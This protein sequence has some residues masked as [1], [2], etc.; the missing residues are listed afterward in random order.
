MKPLS[1]EGRDPLYRIEVKKRAL[2][3]VPL[4]P[5]A[6]REHVI[7]LISMLETDPVPSR[8]FD[9]IKL[10]GYPSSYRVRLGGI[11]VVYKVDSVEHVITVS[12]IESRGRAY[13]DL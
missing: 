2:R 4:L 5:P 3:V 10:E 1:K 7:E 8:D 6:H 11:R 13:K 12:R 9:I